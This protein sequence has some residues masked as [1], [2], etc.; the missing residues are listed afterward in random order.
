MTAFDPGD[1]GDGLDQ[2]PFEQF[3][4]TALDEKDFTQ[5][6]H[7][8]N[9]HP[10]LLPIQ[11]DLYNKLAAMVNTERR[12]KHS[13]T[14]VYPSLELLAVWLHLKRGDYVTPHME[15]LVKVGAIYKETRR[16][17]SGLRQRNRYAV[18]FAPPEGY[19]GP[20]NLTDVMALTKPI[21]AER[22]RERRAH[23]TASRKA[24]RDGG[25]DGQPKL[26]VVE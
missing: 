16:T 1:V 22:T 24:R 19:E 13:D 3:E 18:R 25:D 11:R 5:I 15:Q 12:R 4:L 2:D 26:E 17:G 23:K 9:F 20:K 21:A 8:V 6:H 7:W 10:D 14:D